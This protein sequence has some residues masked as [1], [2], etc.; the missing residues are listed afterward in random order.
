MN[1]LFKTDCS[2]CCFAVVEGDTQTGC[3]LYRTDKFRKMNMLEEIEKDGKKFFMVNGVC[4]ACRSKVWLDKHVDYP[5]SD[6]Y[7]EIRFSC[8]CVIV[9]YEEEK[10]V[11]VTNIV[12]SVKSCVNQ[13]GVKPTSILVAVKSL[14][15]ELKP[16]YDTLNEICN[17]ANVPFN[18]TRVMEPEADYYRTEYLAVTKCRSPYFFLL[19]SGDVITSK[20]LHAIDLALNVDMKKVCMIDGEGVGL[21]LMSKIYE[22]LVPHVETTI[23]DKVR[24]M[25]EEQE[26][27][28]ML[29]S[30]KDICSE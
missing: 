22:S 8:D 5:L 4:N 13:E 29:F 14:S 24:D 3:K 23:Q 25:A 6:L 27:Q 16:L 28:H 10:D 11:L 12:K 2:T 26:C 19:Q 18:L 9:S 30:W 7:E 20:T 1:N 17:Q 15:V 21:V